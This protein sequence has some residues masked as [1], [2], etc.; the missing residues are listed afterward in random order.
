MARPKT[1]ST[2]EAHRIE[3]FYLYEG[4]QPS[5]IAKHFKRKFTV[6]QVT[7]LVYCRKWSKRRKEI[8]ALAVK[9]PAEVSVESADTLL[10]EVSQMRTVTNDRAK[11]LADKAFQMGVLAGNPRDLN[12]SRH[13]PRRSSLEARRWVSIVRKPLVVIHLTSIM[14]MQ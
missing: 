9:K 6:K 12:S 14:S 5:Q 10:A 7:D 1:F 2:E 11:E 3:E 4:L 8:Q 13:L